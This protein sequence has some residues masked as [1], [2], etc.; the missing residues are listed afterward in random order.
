MMHDDDFSIQTELDEGKIN[1]WLQLQTL[2]MLA[3]LT[4]VLINLEPVGMSAY[5]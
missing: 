5:S 1:L 4:I 2:K 3:N